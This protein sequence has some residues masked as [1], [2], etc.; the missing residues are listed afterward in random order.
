M[1]LGNG[2]LA[3]YHNLEDAD[4]E[5]FEAWHTTEHIPERVGIPGF[6]RGRRYV[7]IDDRTNPQYFILYEGNEVEVFS[8][9]AYLQRLNAPTAWTQQVSRTMTL[10]LRTACT[11]SHTQGQG[12]GDY[13]GTWQLSPTTD[14]SATRTDLVKRIFPTVQDV[15]DVISIHLLEANLDVTRV[16]TLEKDTRPGEDGTSDWIVVV[17]TDTPDTLDAVFAVLARN[18]SAPL[19]QSHWTE[20]QLQAMQRDVGEI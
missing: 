13:C 9:P 8:A 20:Y 18:V 1:L 17:E 7:G 14:R 11:V 12:T 3:N 4:R 6:M 19:S 2:A 10:T 5:L 16:D 15:S